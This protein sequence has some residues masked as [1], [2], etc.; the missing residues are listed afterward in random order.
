MPV[1]ETTDEST[2]SNF[3]SNSDLACDNFIATSFE[4]PQTEADPILE[5]Q[6]KIAAL[7]TKLANCQ[8]KLREAEEENKILV[9]WQFS[10]DKIK[11]DNSAIL[12]YI[13]FPSYDALIGFFNY[14]KQ[15]IPKLQYW[16]GENSLK[17][18]K[19]YQTDDNKNKPGPSRKLPPLEEFWLV[20]V[21]LKAGLFVQD[22]ADRFGISI[23]S[24][25]RICIS[26]I[27]FLHYE[28]KDLFPFPSQELVQKNMPKKFAQYPTTRIILDCTEFELFIQGPLAMLAQSE[29]WSGYKHHN[30]WKLLVGITPNGQVT[31]LSQL[32]GGRVSDKQITGESGVLELLEAGDNV[33]VDRGFDIAG[34]VPDGV[35]VNMPPFL[36]GREQMT[37]AETEETMTIVSV[38][39]HVERAIRRLKTYHILDGTLPNTLS[40]Y[41]TQIATVCGLLTNFLPPLLP[42]A[43]P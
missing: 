6:A 25:S 12:F 4:T 34:I 1:T 7:E 19:P 41:G 40:P 37:A 20:L 32:W 38:R 42:P 18:S 2:S 30:T 17:E 28:L 16:K 27:N 43:E 22:L 33:M 14:I 35:A 10:L 26:W 23:S 24:V 21:R 11:H 36:A 15:N 9:G 13:G 5:L 3:L 39:I 31:Y 29:T 8:R